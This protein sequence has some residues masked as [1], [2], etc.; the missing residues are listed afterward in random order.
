MKRSIGILSIFI[1]CILS[2]C[3]LIT[4]TSILQKS[5]DVTPPPPPESGKATVIGRVFS[6]KTGNP[7]GNTIV[8]L[9][10]VQHQEDKVLFV[11]DAAFSPAAISDGNG[12]FIFSNVPA[13][14]Y[15][16]TVG[17]FF[18]AWKAYE[19]GGKPHVFNA[20]PDQVL[21]VNNIKVDL[22]PQ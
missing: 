8:R 15:V 19:E 1:A 17:E 7:M 10:E 18:S 20:V 3:S 21:N 22:N 13:G 6:S 5:P 9:A 4:N 12:F 14:E 2:S 16:I 11:L